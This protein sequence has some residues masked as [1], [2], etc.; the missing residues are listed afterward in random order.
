MAVNA[1]NV[2]AWQSGTGGLLAR[3]SG[4]VDANPT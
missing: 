2:L 1:W 3:W 4:F